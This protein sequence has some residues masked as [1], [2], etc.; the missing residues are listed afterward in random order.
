MT[1]A[2]KT[3][4]ID[5]TMLNPKRPSSRGKTLAIAVILAAIAAILT[6][7]VLTKK[8]Q[9]Q[10]APP[11]P[12]VLTPVVMAAQDIPART[13]ITDSMLKVVDMDTAP[14]DSVQRQVD[15]VGKVTTTPI[16]NGQPITN[17]DVTLRGP[18]MGLAYGILPGYRGVTIQLDPVS[19]V[20][21]FIKPGDHV[22]IIATF[23]AG[24][25][26]SVTRTVLQNVLLL[27]TG[28]DVLPTHAATG[29]GLSGSNNPAAPDGNTP[30]PEEIPNATVAVTPEEAQ[31]LM[32]AANKGK[33]LLTLRAANDIAN[34][35]I[36][37]LHSADVTTIYP[38]QDAPP[39]PPQRLAPPPVWQPTQALPVPSTVT[40]IRG[41]D[42]KTVTVNP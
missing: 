32:L 6:F 41:S 15:L 2:D 8:T 34:R 17:S 4:R 39:A 9:Q 19:S 21:G 16:S 23:D 18:E 22:D 12:V 7:V 31:R 30:K 38:K 42:S 25:N 29:N 3:L 36:P 37:V 35:D 24:N 14:N 13:Q 20:A 33:L 28:A 1:T 27:A 5:R 10:A 26:Q 11:P 40:V